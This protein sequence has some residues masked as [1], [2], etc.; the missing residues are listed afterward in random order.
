MQ[1]EDSYSGWKKTPPEDWRAIK[2]R[3]L[4]NHKQQSSNW[5]CE[6]C[7]YTCQDLELSEHD[8]KLDKKIKDSLVCSLMMQ[9][10]ILTSH[11]HGTSIFVF[12]IVW[13]TAKPKYLI[14]RGWFFP[15]TAR[16]RISVHLWHGLSTMLFWAAPWSCKTYRID[17]SDTI[18]HFDKIPHNCLC[19]SFSIWV[20]N[21]ITARGFK[22]NARADLHHT[23]AIE[24][25][26]LQWF[27]AG[28]CHWASA[29][30]KRDRLWLHFERL[31][32]R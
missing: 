19:F 10:E 1:S 8:S 6:C 3:P 26:V 2:W 28:T 25:E 7:C 30:H 11:I 17:I 4:F 5:S 27:L 29:V 18:S 13:A 32:E 21:N 24:V 15:L 14:Y 23:A 9:P 16:K 20:G 22:T 12:T 31:K